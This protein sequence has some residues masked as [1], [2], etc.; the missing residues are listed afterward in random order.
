MADKSEM[1]LGWDF[2]AQVLGASMGSD[3]ASS[4]FDIESDRFKQ[5][6]D[7]VDHL[8]KSINQHPH[9]QLDIEKFKGFVA[10]E[11]HAHTFNIDALRQGSEHR[12]Y[13]LQENGYA[14]VDVATNFGK[15]YSLK[16]SNT[17]ESA[18][19]MQ[20]ALHKE[21]R[22]PKYQGQ[23]RLIA[24]EQLEDAKAWAHR[25]ALKDS[26]N[27]P[28]VARAHMD[29]EKHLVAN[30]SDEQGVE[31]RELSIAESKQIAKEAKK[32]VF[33]PEKHGLDK[34]SL[35]E[36]VRIDYVDQA[37][38]A[39]LTAASITAILQLAPELYKAIDYLIKH[40]EIDLNGIK[41][42]GEKIIS[43]SGESFLRGSIAYSVEMSIQKGMLGEAL[44]QVTP[45]IVGVAVTVILGAMKDSV[46]VA[47]GKM[48]SNEMGMHFVET[49]C[50]SSAY[51]AGAKIGGMIAQA[52]AP[53]LPG[54]GYALGSLLG[55]SVAAVYNYGKSQL[56][57]F[58]IDTG[59]TCFGLVEQ[60]YELPEQVL[61]ELGIDTIPIARAQVDTAD[62]PRAQIPSAQIEKAEYETIDI[63]MLRR[64]LIGVNKIGYI[65]G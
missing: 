27:R 19:N 52:L 63:T 49:L 22:M 39:G 21:T 18:E 56:I 20:S 12:A 53:Q 47:A 58:C 4:D 48:S 25:R 64:G 26:S 37:L 5:I 38:K 9:I 6:L 34:A 42:S 15:K 55:C 13:T 54:I 8:K 14:S 41:R 35:L 17:P 28:E 3:R 11:W 60:N 23:D 24:A 32:G 51:L 59:F 45:P 31:S 44:K 61:R 57:S 65:P 62:I 29:T 10:E 16:Y 43:A 36:E 7:A 2:M 1:R 33:D 46:L 50:I 40:G 30:I